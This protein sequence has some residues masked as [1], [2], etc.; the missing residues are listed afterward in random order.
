MLVKVCNQ[1]VS[2][3]PLQKTGSS[4]E[5]KILPLDTKEFRYL[6]FRAIGAMEWPT[7]GPNVSILKTTN[8]VLVGRPSS[9]S[10]HTLNTIAP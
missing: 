9:T 1:V 4:H 2:P 8:P 6:R 10:G 3:I 7:A 5:K